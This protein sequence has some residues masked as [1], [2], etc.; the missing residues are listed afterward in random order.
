MSARVSMHTWKPEVGIRYVQ[1]DANEDD[2]DNNDDERSLP[3]LPP[4]QIW[5]SQIRL[6]ELAREA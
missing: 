3:P 4:P 5:S 2:G 6:D 1:Y